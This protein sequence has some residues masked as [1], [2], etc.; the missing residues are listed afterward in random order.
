MNVNWKKC[1]ENIWCDLLTLNLENEHFNSL[2]GVYIIWHSGSNQ[3]VVRVGQGII[4]D[5]LKEHR[6]DPIILKY[7]GFGLYVTWA[8]VD[9]RY[10]DG[11]ERFLANE[12]KPLEG[13]RYPD[14]FP[15]Q[16]NLPL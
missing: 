3:R 10:L 16:V 11:V 14:T 12:L 8:E 5:R 13:E 2:I 6:E 15:I 7:K 9:R 1:Q 4:K